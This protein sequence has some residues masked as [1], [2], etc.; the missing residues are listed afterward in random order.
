MTYIEELDMDELTEMF[1]DKDKHE[2]FKEKLAEK[3]AEGE[4]PCQNYH[5]VDEVANFCD[6]EEIND[7]C[8]PTECWLRV[9]E[10][11]E[12]EG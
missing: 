11:I 5:F 3:L 6:E 10:K 7:R 1:S 4:P 12:K 9:F 2:Q 8:N